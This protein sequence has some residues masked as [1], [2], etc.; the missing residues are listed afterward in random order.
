[1]CVFLLRKRAFADPAQGPRMTGQ[2][3]MPCRTT[4]EN[5]AWVGY[6]PTGDA[7]AIAAKQKL[8]NR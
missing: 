1:M 6:R 7:G 2:E 4:G 3:K 5:A 8:L